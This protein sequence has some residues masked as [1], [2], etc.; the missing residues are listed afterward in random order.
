[1]KYSSRLPDRGPQ[2]RPAYRLQAEYAISPGFTN[3]SARG[4][5]FWS[6][7][8]ASGWCRIHLV[9]QVDEPGF[10]PH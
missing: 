6:L 9:Y 8:M 5:S 2:V 10:K 7:T 4:I 1:M 3:V